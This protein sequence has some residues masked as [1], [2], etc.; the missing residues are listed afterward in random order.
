MVI[1]PEH[2]GYVVF[3]H[4]DRTLRM[5]CTFFSP[6]GY[7][8]YT[9]SLTFNFLRLSNPAE[10]AE[11]EL[12]SKHFRRLDQSTV[13]EKIY[14]LW[15]RNGLRI[16]SLK[17]NFQR[18]KWGCECDECGCFASVSRPFLPKEGNSYKPLQP[19]RREDLSTENEQ[20]MKSSVCVWVLVLEKM[21]K[22][23]KD[24]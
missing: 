17:L 24:Q 21:R 23:Q 1:A 18:S 13:A 3:Y 10:L 16:I 6:P 9:A 12:P 4:T 15:G 8:Y 11:C 22:L 20:K 2:G 19:E 5:R 14:N 7:F